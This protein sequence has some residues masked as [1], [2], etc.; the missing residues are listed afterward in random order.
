MGFNSQIK[1]KIFKIDD[2]LTIENQWKSIGLKIVFTNGCFDILHLGHID[3]LSK[4]RDLGDKL[5]IGLNSDES[6]KRIKGKSRP[7][8][9]ENSRAFILAAF[10]FVDAVILFDEDTPYNIISKLLPNV[11]VKGSDYALNEIV[12]ANLV[13]ASG[14]IVETINFLDGYS[15]SSIINK[16]IKENIL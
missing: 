8:Q 9:D 1:S 2:F 14:G 5:I 12:G 4:A 16:I 13:I 10:G 7:I 3:Y 11:L 6:V 15:S